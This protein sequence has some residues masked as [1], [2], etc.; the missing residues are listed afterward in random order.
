[1]TTSMTAAQK[2]Q[3]ID[4]LRDDGYIINFNKTKKPYIRLSKGKTLR[5]KDDMWGI[6]TPEVRDYL[7]KRDGGTTVYITCQL[8]MDS[9]HTEHYSYE[10]NDY[11][12]NGYCSGSEREMNVSVIYYASFENTPVPAMVK[13][14][15]QTL[16]ISM[17]EAANNSDGACGGGSEWC[18]ASDVT[19]KYFPSAGVRRITLSKLTIS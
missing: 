5:E 13:I 7:K 4:E 15:G 9:H 10:D 11:F 19:R 1:M 3:L 12:D 8:V 18:E 17:L 6:M 16:I 2:R 14:D